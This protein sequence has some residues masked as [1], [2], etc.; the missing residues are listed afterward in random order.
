ML[1]RLG[2]LRPEP[3]ELVDVQGD[4]HVARPGQPLRV[5]SWN[6]QFCASRA[7]HFWYDGGRDVHCDPGLVRRTTAQI[8]DE[9]GEVDVA[10]LQEVDRDATRTGRVDQLPVLGRAHPVHVSTPY[11]RAPYVPAPSHAPLGR[12]DLHLAV[13]SRVALASATRHALPP[14]N[15]PAI[16]RLF[17]L[18]RAILSTVM[19]IAGG[20]TLTLAVTHLS[21][22]T[23]GD[24]TLTRQCAV[25][26]DWM[27]A[28]TGPWLL[29]GDFNLMPPG[30]DPRRVGEPPDDALALLVPEFRLAVDPATWTYQPWGKPPDRTID[31]VFC[32]RDLVV[33]GSRVVPTELSDHLAIEVELRVPSRAR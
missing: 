25:V 16:R 5:R 26:R 1:Q 12:V 31:Y 11:H 17:N 32:S 27:R 10:L 22:F 30:D 9:L 4:A 21:A 14:M 23:Q 2:F 33:E 7:P 28:Q 19:P 29:A 3:V 18:R 15:E 8:A 24:D 20:G 13:L 6:L